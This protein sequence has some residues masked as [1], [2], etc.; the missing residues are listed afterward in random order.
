MVQEAVRAIPDANKVCVAT[1]LPRP[2]LRRGWPKEPA[3]TF[4]LKHSRAV[5]VGAENGWENVPQTR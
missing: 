4:A 2:F 3:Q 5:S 1:P